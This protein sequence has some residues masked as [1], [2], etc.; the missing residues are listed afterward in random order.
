MAVTPNGLH[1]V[2]ASDDETLKVWDQGTGTCTATPSGHRRR[3][4]FVAI[5]PDGLQAMPGSNDETLKVWDLR[6]GTCTATL[7][8]HVDYVS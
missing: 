7:T 1:A 2:S 6:T 3:V 8:G 4:Y 5:T